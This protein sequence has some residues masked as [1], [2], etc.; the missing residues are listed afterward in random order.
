M[1]SIRQQQE[2]LEPSCTI[3]C[4]LTV[5][6][7]T[8]EGLAKG[9]LT[10]DISPRLPVGTTIEVLGAIP[11]E[12]VEVEIGLPA[13][14]RAKQRKHPHP[15]IVRLKKVLTADPRRTTP[16]CPVF[17]DC[18]GCRL[19][20]IPY[21][22][23]LIWKQERVRQEIAST[24]GDPDKVLPVRGME[25]PWNFRNQMRFAVD[26]DGHPG[27]TALGTHRV[28]PL[29]NCP[30]AHPY[31]NKTLK[32]LASHSQ[33]KP[34]VLVR[35]GA[36]TGEILLQP[37]PDDITSA[38]LK[39]N[40]ILPQIAIVHEKLDGLRFAMRPSSFFQ[41]N[42]IQAE[43]MAA[44]ICEEV[45]EAKIVADAYC[46]V[47]TFAALLARHIPLVIAIEESA[48]AVADARANLIAL[49]LD[50]QVQVI[51]GKTEHILPGLDLPLDAIVLDPPRMGCQRPV[52]DAI[53]ARRISKLVYVSC[54]PSTLARD[55]NIL[56]SQD[57]GYQVSHIQPIDMFPQTY[58]IECVAVLDFVG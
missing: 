48:S 21:I 34:Q 26:R 29:E 47:G 43:V 52:L 13:I 54:D 14:W 49:G 5:R 44:L 24:G 30:I 33:K 37:V 55:L 11:G 46:G 51:Q 8:K 58:H 25:I 57:G 50:K 42:T 10:E 16:R 31:I 7:W 23:Q 53:I 12:V 6:E 4:T 18:G 22:E 27:L 38:D 35:C 17:G 9:Q 36:Q 41:T 32:I 2:P 20:H 39:E 3:M 19:Q 15:P 56:S 28:I 1:S 40:M 45:K